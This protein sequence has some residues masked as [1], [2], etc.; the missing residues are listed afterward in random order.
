MK[1]DWECLGGGGGWE[2]WGCRRCGRE[3]FPNVLWGLWF[4]R[5]WLNKCGVASPSTK[6]TRT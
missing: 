2:L 4:V 1:H 5:W 6:E 3:R